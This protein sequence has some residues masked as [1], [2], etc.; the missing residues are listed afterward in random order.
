M[1]DSPTDGKQF[2]TI[3]PRDLVGEITNDLL[4]DVHTERGE[5]ISSMKR[6]LGYLN[7]LLPQDAEWLRARGYLL[8]LVRQLRE[9][10]TAEETLLQ[11]FFKSSNES[12]M[13]H[14]SL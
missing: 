10:S 11:E 4:E 9:L 5:I 2:R 8:Y 3:I 1:E 6:Y 14:V 12:A 7:T 13:D